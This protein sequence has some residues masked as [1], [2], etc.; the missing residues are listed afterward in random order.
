MRPAT[1]HQ[2]TR[3]RIPSGEHTHDLEVPGDGASASMRVPVS[4]VMTPSALCVPEHLSLTTLEEILLDRDLSGLPV[5]DEQGKLVGFVEMTDIVREVHHR[6]D[7]DEVPGT[8]T[9]AQVMSPIALELPAS[10]PIAKAVHLMA[11]QQAH[12]IP[13]V[14]GDGALLGIVTAGDIVRYLA[15]AERTAKLPAKLP[16]RGSP[17]WEVPDHKH[18]TDA[19][20]VVALSFLAGGVAHQVNNALTPMRLSLGRLTSFELSQ[21]PLSPERLHRIELLQDVRE[22]VDRIEQII[23]ELKAFSHTDG[24]SRVVDVPAELEVA[25]GL[26]AHEI[27]HRA[28]LVCDYATVPTIRAK[29][30]EL[31]QVFLN[32]L[33]NAAQATPEGQAHVNEIRVMTRTDGRGRAV[34][35]I[36]DTGS[37]IPSDVATRI[38]E[39]FFTT[40]PERTGLG[41]GLTLSRDIVAALDGEITIDSVVGKG[42]TVR[43]ALPPG[44]GQPVASQRPTPSRRAPAAAPER[45]RILIVD[46][47][48]PVA[49]ALALELEAHDVVVA[50]SGRE[51]LTILAHDK[52]FDMILCDLMMP[53][54]SGIEVYEALQRTD[55]ALLD[56]VVLM[57]GGAFTSR[58]RQFLSEVDTLVL[59]KPFHPG[60]L[61][62]LV[63]ALGSRRELTA[64]RA[65]PPGPRDAQ[66]SC[67]IG[68][69]GARK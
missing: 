39:P 21:R 53:E 7:T 66:I 67:G 11:T 58:A 8:R 32:L 2:K 9:V 45:R 64:S 14:S 47:D 50:E 49:A 55:P 59:E 31:R 36:K 25:I 28:R 24:P 4:A 68:R 46:D 54:V 69:R 61:H 62:D 44:P 6:G 13:V 30:A 26:A 27:R 35:E 37:G 56:H 23:R 5:V 17:A 52:G 3:Q 60:Q 16:D 34:I 1:R 22:G 19:D 42:T 29:P 63:H 38:F 57:T 18:L 10:C 65:L 33:V 51:A 41:L 20:R 43:V 12:R 15:G 48:R 40:R